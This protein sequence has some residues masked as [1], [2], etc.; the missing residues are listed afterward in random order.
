MTNVIKC[1]GKTNQNS[2]NQ[3]FKNLIYTFRNV[4]LLFLCVGFLGVG[5]VK[6]VDYPQIR[7]LLL[8]G[9]IPQLIIYLIGVIEVALSVLMFYQPT[10]HRALLAVCALMFG[11]TCYHI[12]HAQ[13][14]YLTAPAVIITVVLSILWIENNKALKIIKS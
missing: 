9:G 5:M 2:K 6:L 11:A 14:A 10:R 12:Y 1:T 7:D 8:S 3:I 4:F 13:W